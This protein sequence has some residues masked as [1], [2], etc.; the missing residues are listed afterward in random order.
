MKN[1]T[2][3]AIALTLALN[4]GCA[5]IPADK[6]AHAGISGLAAHFVGTGLESA[7]VEKHPR[8]FTAA[9]ATLIVGH[10]KEVADRQNG[11]VYSKADMYADIGGVGIWLGIEYGGDWLKQL[12]NRLTTKPE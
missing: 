5:S 4:S 10:N 7:G 3:P 1:L 11:G 2:I 9:F 12:Y 8:R 6:A